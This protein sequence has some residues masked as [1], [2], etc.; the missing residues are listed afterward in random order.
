MVAMPRS[1]TFESFLGEPTTSGGRDVLW[2]L[3]TKWQ[4]SSGDPDGIEKKIWSGRLIRDTPFTW[5][6]SWNTFILHDPRASLRLLT[7]EATRPHPSWCGERPSKTDVTVLEEMGVP[8]EYS[9]HEVAPSQHEIDLK[10]RDALTMA[11]STM[12]YRLVVKRG[13]FEK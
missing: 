11:D 5:G 2:C 7:R 10:Y 13:G 8:V 1:S 9:H 3:R 4:S 12:I 6:L